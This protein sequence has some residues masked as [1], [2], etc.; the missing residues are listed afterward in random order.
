M[1]LKAS[2]DGFHI[3]TTVEIAVIAGIAAIGKPNCSP[4]LTL[5][6]AP[7]PLVTCHLD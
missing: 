1:L 2:F 3:V 6:A 7:R 4:L 5:I